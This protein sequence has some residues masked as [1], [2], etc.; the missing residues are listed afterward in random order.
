MNT[1]DTKGIQKGATL[2]IASFEAVF[3]KLPLF[4]IYE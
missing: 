1:A 4:A 2:P 3:S